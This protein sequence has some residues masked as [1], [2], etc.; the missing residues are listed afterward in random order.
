MFSWDLYVKIIKSYKPMN[1]LP[2][3]FVK[4]FKIVF[5]TLYKVSNEVWNQISNDE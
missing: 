5:I 4:T 3:L 2:I 1:A